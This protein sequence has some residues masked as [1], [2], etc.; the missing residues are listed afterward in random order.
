MNVFGVI[1]SSTL[2]L[3]SCVVYYKFK[4]KTECIIMNS[5][6]I[7][8]YN[9]NQSSKGI[10]VN[11]LRIKTEK[12]IKILDNLKIMLTSCKFNPSL[13]LINPYAQLVFHQFLKKKENKLKRV[14]LTLKCGGIVSLDYAIFDAKFKPTSMKTSN[15]NLTN[16]SFDDKRNKYFEDNEEGNS[17]SDNCELGLSNTLSENILIVLHGVL[18]GSETP[19]MKDICNFFKN[20]KNSFFSQIIFIQNKGINDT[21]LSKPKPYNAESI[22]EVKEAIDYI[23]S[24]NK[25]CRLYFIG[26]SLGSLILTQLFLAHPNIQNVVGFVS[27]SNPFHLKHSYR[28]MGYFTS[29]ILLYIMRNKIDNHPILYSKYDVKKGSSIK[30]ICE[31]DKEFTFSVHDEINCL[32]SYWDRTSVNNKLWK[33]KYFTL[34]INSEDDDIT[35]LNEVDIDQS[36]FNIIFSKIKPIYFNVKNKIWISCLFF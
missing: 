14:Y 8:N 2:V 3:L 11:E 36:N 35:A 18:G 10:I 5:K 19:Q 9:K 12:F 34:F 13:Y 20:E 1:T 21:P 30:K 22:E 23:I 32:E 25:N 33:L 7:E 31:F 16:S 15:F 27:I 24:I 26:I 17:K 6:D 4:N 29:Q 28:N